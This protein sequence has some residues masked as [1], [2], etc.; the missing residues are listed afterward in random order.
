MTAPSGRMLPERTD[1]IEP[2]GGF[3]AADVDEGDEGE[4]EDGKGD[5]VERAGSEG[6]RAGTKGIEDRS[7]AEVKEAG[8][9]RQI[10]HPVGP[11]GDEAGEVTEGLAGPD[12]E[13]AFF[14]M[15]LGEFHD[16]GRK[17]DEETE[18]GADPDHRTLGP[19]A[20]AVAVQRTPRETDT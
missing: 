16:G 8:K 3:D 13:A 9:K 6:L 18:E 11:G 17:R 14:R 5:E 19:T 4:R 15:P 12:V 7:G 10:G 1:V 20:A 2:F